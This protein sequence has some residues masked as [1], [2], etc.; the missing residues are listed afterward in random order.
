M[1]ALGRHAQLIC[2]KGQALIGTSI[3]LY[4][5]LQF[6]LCRVRMSNT[7]SSEDVKGY[8]ALSTKSTRTASNG[9]SIFPSAD[10]RRTPAASKACTSP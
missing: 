8:A 10:F 4:R 6:A 1:L 3:W 7:G 9:N 2:V 5:Q